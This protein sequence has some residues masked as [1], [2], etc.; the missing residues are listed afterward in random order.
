MKTDENLLI[1]IHSTFSKHREAYRAALMMIL[2][3]YVPTYL[4]SALNNDNIVSIE[5]IFNVLDL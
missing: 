4:S 3:T 5:Y 2:F 1:G